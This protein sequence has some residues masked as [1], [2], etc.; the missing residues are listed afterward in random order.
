MAYAGVTV[1]VY[2]IIIP[3][4]YVLLLF[5]SRDCLKAVQGAI[6][7]EAA[8]ARELWA[9]SR[10]QVYFYEIVECSRRVLLSGAV[11]FVYLNSAV[12]VATSHLLVY[13][14]VLSC[15]HGPGPLCG[16]LAHVDS[17]D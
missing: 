7:A 12:Q 1:N 16:P 15:A 9:P 2:P 8:I 4:G 11:G 17:E 6:T 3:A 5:R 13:I 10:P 14:Y